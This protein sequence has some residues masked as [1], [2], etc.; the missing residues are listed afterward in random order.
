MDTDTILLN[1]YDAH[2]SGGR[3]QKL[4]VVLRVHR[5]HLISG[6]QSFNSE[7]AGNQ[8]VAF[9]QPWHLPKLCSPTDVLLE[10]IPVPLPSGIIKEESNVL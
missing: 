4:L 10:V 9:H 7:A 3:G 8:W 1:T 6:H 5:G 2:R